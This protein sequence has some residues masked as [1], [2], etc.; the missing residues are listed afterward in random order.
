MCTRSTDC[1]KATRSIDAAHGVGSKPLNWPRLNDRTFQQQMAARPT[2]RIQAADARRLLLADRELRQG[3]LTNTKQSPG[4]GSHSSQLL[5][6]K[7]SSLRS[8]CR[9]MSA[10]LCSRRSGPR[11]GVGTLSS[12]CL[13][14][15]DPALHHMRDFF[16]FG[17]VLVRNSCG[18]HRRA[19]AR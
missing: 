4:A 13:I 5:T 11:K 2:R 3:G 1:I 9:I 6:D 18:L 16:T 17:R 8:A 7:S 10:R 12:Q 19:A 14:W 15:F